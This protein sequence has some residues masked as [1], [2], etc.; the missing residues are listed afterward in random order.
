MIN[1]WKEVEKLVRNHKSFINPNEATIWRI[2]MKQ[3]PHGENNSPRLRKPLNW[4]LSFQIAVPHWRIILRNSYLIV[5]IS[6]NFPGFRGKVKVWRRHVSS[7][8]PSRKLTRKSRLAISVYDLLKSLKK[9][10]QSHLTIHCRLFASEWRL[11]EGFW[12]DSHAKC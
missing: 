11:C 10:M 5:H 1:R 4:I 12:S 8:F 3:R 6:R 9:V 2:P 7:S